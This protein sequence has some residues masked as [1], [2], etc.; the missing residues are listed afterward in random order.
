MYILFAIFF[1]YLQ[2]STSKSIFY[3]WNLTLNQW[4]IC[5]VKNR[6]NFC[7][8]MLLIDVYMICLTKC[9]PFFSV[10]ATPFDV[11]SCI[12]KLKDFTC[13]IPSHPFPSLNLVIWGTVSHHIWKLWSNACINDLFGQHDHINEFIDSFWI[14][15]YHTI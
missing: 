14:C 9:F 8:W 2:S 5:T 3:N 10:I 11:A 1:V 6:G 15:V 12:F 4:F 13:L 7:R